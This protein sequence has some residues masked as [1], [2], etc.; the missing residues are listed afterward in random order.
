MSFPPMPPSSVPPMPPAALSL[1]VG[2]A[3]AQSAARIEQ[4]VRLRGETDTKDKMLRRIEYDLYYIDHWSMW[5]DI[6][7]LFLT[8]FSSKSYRNAV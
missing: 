5:L 7:I 6:R 1:P 2:A 8:V 4:A 3:T